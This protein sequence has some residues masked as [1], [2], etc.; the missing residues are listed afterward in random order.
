MAYNPSDE[1]DNMFFFHEYKTG[2]LITVRT[3][4]RHTALILTLARQEFC[5]W[6]IPQQ[7]S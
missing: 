5:R 4:L 2:Q 7:V 6:I 1:L 3:K